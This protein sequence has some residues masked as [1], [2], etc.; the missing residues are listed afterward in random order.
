MYVHVG[1]RSPAAALEHGGMEEPQPEPV[2][3]PVQAQV[4]EAVHASDT[5]EY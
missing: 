3:V 4:L 1:R 5:S 2:P